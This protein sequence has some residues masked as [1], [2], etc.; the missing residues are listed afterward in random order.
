MTIPSR[1]FAQ[2]LQ[3]NGCCC[4]ATT[5]S[6]FLN[7]VLFPCELNNQE[8]QQWDES[9]VNT[10][11]PPLMP[12]PLNIYCKSDSIKVTQPVFLN[13]STDRTLGKKNVTQLH[14]QFNMTTSDV[15]TI[16]KNKT[17]LLTV[18]TWLCIFDNIHCF[19]KVTRKQHSFSVW[20][21]PRPSCPVFSMTNA[22][23]Q[24]GQSEAAV[25]KGH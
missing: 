12:L 7:I 2:R 17:A 23:T 4:V 20:F 25:C 14:L 15:A 19:K 21:S 8:K 22:G 6:W 1:E 24:T 16:L 9:L 5:Q 18:G 10:I 13:H 3:W 11:F